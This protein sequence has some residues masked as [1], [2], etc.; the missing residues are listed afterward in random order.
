MDEL[1]TRVLTACRGELSGLYPG[2]NAAF[3]CLPWQEGGAVGTDGTRFFVNDSLVTLYGAD[4]AR[5]RRGYLHCL[6]HCLFLHIRIPDRVDPEL[7]G[8]ACD[9]WVEG[10]L[11]TL[12]EPRL[13]APD[14]RRE[15]L[16]LPGDPWQILSRLER[17]P[18]LLEERRAVFSFDDHSLWP[19]AIPASL[20]SRWEGLSSGGGGLGT[21][22]RGG[23]TKAEEE[24]VEAY[25]GSLYDFRKYL[26]RF[27]IPREELITDEE[28]FDYLFYQLGMDLYGNMPLL[29]PLE[30]REVVALDALVIAIDTSGSCDAAL[31]GRFLRET[32]GIFST[33]ENF[34]RKMKV[35]FFQCD[36]CLQDTAVITCR[37]QWERY[38][39]NVRIKGRGGTDFT[40]VFREVERLRREG[41]LPKPRALLYFTD[42][43]G[44]YPGKPDYET[45]FVLS[46]PRR[47]PELVPKWANI[48]E[49]EGER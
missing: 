28:S 9:I 40:P 21:G 26:R 15:A 33:Q 22:S 11:D 19:R 27:T 17:Q 41:M 12:K 6:L 46:G 38:A 20:Q 16:G 31:V 34:F 29:E 25:R 30:Y 35:V 32:Y 13:L 4:P 7:W 45:V 2:L 39:D 48:L 47:H 44:I 18:D 36:C 43:D 5:V 42:G 14:P 3:A 10:Y 24:S 23:K 8:L 49:L 37:E 1:L